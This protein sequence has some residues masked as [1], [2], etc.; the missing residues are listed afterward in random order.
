MEDSSEN[1]T[2]SLRI[3]TSPRQQPEI[4]LL[5][6][7]YHRYLKKN[8]HQPIMSFMWPPPGVYS[9]FRR[10]LVGMIHPASIP[11]R[12]L[13]HNLPNMQRTVQMSASFVQYTPQLPGQYQQL[14]Q[15]SEHF[16][17][18]EMFAIIRAMLGSEDDNLAN[19]AL[20]FDLQLGRIQ[21][22]GMN[23]GFMV[24]DRLLAAQMNIV[25][26]QLQMRAGAGNPAAMSGQAQMPQA[27]QPP[28]MAGFPNDFQGQNQDFGRNDQYPPVNPGYQQAGQNSGGGEYLPAQGPAGSQ[29]GQ[30]GGIPNNN[31]GY[32][33]F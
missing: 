19:Q 1:Q 16:S 23:N 7:F 20:Q 6:Y 27:T 2:P 31:G 8:K 32:P 14:P 17:D 24:V 4:A 5:F 33:G 26:Q 22:L 30:A 3:R 29:F 9:R 15:S 25:K 13:A 28:D 21:D 10:P 11:P 12:F 18:D